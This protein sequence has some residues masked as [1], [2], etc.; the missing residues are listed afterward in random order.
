M[1]LAQIRSEFEKE[2]PVQS[3]SL[4]DVLGKEW[5]AEWS[6]P[7]STGDE[8]LSYSI[9]LWAGFLAGYVRAERNMKNNSPISQSDKDIGHR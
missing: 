3:K 5:T 6:D 8:Y 4:E 7:Y 1:T 9:G 2:Y